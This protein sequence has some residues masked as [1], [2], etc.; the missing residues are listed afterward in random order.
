MR[1]L[2]PCAL[3]LCA[4]AIPAGVEAASRLYPYAGAVVRFQFNEAATPKRYTLAQAGVAV[5]FGK[6]APSIVIRAGAGHAEV[7]LGAR[8]SFR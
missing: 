5:S 8:Y 4:L 1:L 7:E 3:A 2:A 6:V